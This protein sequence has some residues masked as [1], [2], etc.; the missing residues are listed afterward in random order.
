MVS[1]A[2]WIYGL[3]Y[4]NADSKMKL[5]GNPLL[6]AEP[7]SEQAYPQVLSTYV[8]SVY[9]VQM[10]VVQFEESAETTTYLVNHTSEV[11]VQVCV[12]VV[13]DQP[14]ALWL[15]SIDGSL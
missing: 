12:G 1:F 5:A 7:W 9:C 2:V 6:V 15:A 11:G 10:S 4:S 14:E 8:M 13:G 3:R